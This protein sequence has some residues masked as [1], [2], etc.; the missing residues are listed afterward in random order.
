M[1]LLQNLEIF[2]W[3]IRD[4]LYLEAKNST[5]IKHKQTTYDNLKE[6]YL[7]AMEL[8]KLYKIYAIKTVTRQ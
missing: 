1:F 2:S 5:N 6:L 4:F 8:N 7:V 3:F